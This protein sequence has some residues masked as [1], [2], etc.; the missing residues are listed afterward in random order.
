LQWLC[1]DDST[2]IIAIG[3]SLLR[4]PG[5]GIEKRA[6]SDRHKSSAQHVRCTTPAT[7]SRLTPDLHQ[8]TIQHLRAGDCKS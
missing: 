6:E 4:V 2:I 7:A 1:H 8:R 5:I 3:V